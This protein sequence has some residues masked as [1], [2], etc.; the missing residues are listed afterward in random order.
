MKVLITENNRLFSQFLDN[1]FGQL[2]FDRD[3]CYSIKAASSY[4]ES[5]KYDLICINQYL[6]DGLGVEFVTYCNH[7][8]K[9]EKTP[10]LFLTS[11][12]ASVRGIEELRISDV[13]LKNNRQQITAQITRFVERHLDLLFNEGKILLVEDSMAIASVMLGYLE[14]TGYKVLHFLSGEEAWTAFKKELSYGSDSNA[15]DL[16]ISDIMLEG[17]MSGIGLIKK[18]RSIG[19]ARGYI[20]I[21][22]M[23]GDNTDKLRLNLYE[24]GVNDFLKKPF[25]TEELLIRIHNLIT[26][27]RLLDKVHDQRRELFV[28]ANT[29]KLTGCHNRHSL[30]EFAGD[31]LS[32]ATQ[33]GHPISLLVLDLDYF[34]LV[35]DNYGHAMGDIV[36]EAIGELL[37]TSF[38]AED[39]VARFGGEEFVVLINH[40]DARNAKEMS[41]NL[42]QKV[43]Q[44][45]PGNIDISASIGL[46]TMEAG[47]NANFEMLFS[48][49][50]EGVYKA[51]RKGR[52]CVVY[53]PIE[54]KSI[55]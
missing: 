40:C 41:E 8:H 39:L 50:D 3:I 9:N 11:D 20:P 43:E 7:H 55:S 51:K 38:R 31:F 18:I 19:D 53:L 42:R 46:T 26:N 45:K 13:V 1:I 48:L 32:Q 27:K 6:E 12:K 35:N 4:L 24:I 23:T 37:N 25:L 44:L 14:S 16:V 15:F 22:A 17:V 28:L 33:Q 29:D 2:G 36:L 30:M 10:I 52:N 54:S 49:A 34:K 47:Q 21:I 5:E